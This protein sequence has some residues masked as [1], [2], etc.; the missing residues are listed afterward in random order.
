MRIREGKP[1]AYGKHL[2]DEEIA[3]IDAFCL[4]HLNPGALELLAQLQI[5][6]LSYQK[7]DA[8]V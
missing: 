7:E 8:Y 2:S 3:Y 5:P 4:S 6:L 1:H